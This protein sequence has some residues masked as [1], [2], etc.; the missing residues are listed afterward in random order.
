M[1]SEDFS[2]GSFIKKKQNIIL[3]EKSSS[4]LRL[5]STLTTIYFMKIL[6][7]LLEIFISSN[8]ELREGERG[9][10]KIMKKNEEKEG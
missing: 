8:A 3:K 1:W 2:K 6:Y 7:A 10:Y 4:A 5:T 9:V